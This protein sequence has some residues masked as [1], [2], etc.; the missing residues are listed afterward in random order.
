MRVLLVRAQLQDETLPTDFQVAADEVREALQGTSVYL[1]GMMGSGKSTVG[2]LVAKALKYSFFDSDTLIEQLSGTTIAEIFASEGEDAFR[3]VET[4]VLQE[5]APF[6]ECVIATGGG[7]VTRGI[8]WGHMQ[9]GI[10]I[11]L[12]GSP[13]LL[14]GRVVGDG[15]SSRPLLSQEHGAHQAQQQEQQQQHADEYAKTV[16]RLT[17][18]LEDRRKQYEFADIQVP[19]EGD[20]GPDVGAPTGVVAYRI[21]DSLRTRI[22]RDAAYREERKNFTIERAEDVPATLR[23]VQSPAQHEP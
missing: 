22:K 1:V 8:N 18:L 5:L 15:T 7:S 4:Q 14:A 2:K 3:Q 16:A 6:K 10:V 13:E 19:L 20:A 21:L 12:T 17:E 23:V 11:W 9:H